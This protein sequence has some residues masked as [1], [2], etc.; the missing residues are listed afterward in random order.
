MTL[1]ERLEELES[2]VGKNSRNFCQPPSSDGLRKTNSLREPSGNK[3]NSQPGHKGGTLKQIGKPSRID[4]HQLSNQCERCDC[5]P[6]ALRRIGSARRREIALF[7]C[8]RQRQPHL[9]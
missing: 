5:P 4:I 2:K 8:G 3:P 7:A 6:A 9:V 1:W